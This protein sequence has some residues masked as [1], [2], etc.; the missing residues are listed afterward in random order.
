MYSQREI[1]V[2]RYIQPLANPTA[3]FPVHSPCG[4]NEKVRHNTMGIC[5]IYRRSPVPLLLNLHR[6]PG[7]N[8]HTTTFC[9]RL[10]MAVREAKVIVVGQTNVGKTCLAGRM[11][12]PN[13][14]CD[15]EPTA[16]ANYF[17]CPMTV[18]GT[19]VN[20]VIWDTAGQERYRQML[21]MYFR[22]VAAAVFVYSIVDAPTLDEVDGWKE[23]VREMVTDGAVPL[24]LVGTKED[25]S[26]Q[27]EVPREVGEEKA[28]AIGATFFETSAVTGKNLH[29]LFNEVARQILRRAAE[30]EPEPVS[31]VTIPTGA[32]QATGSRC[33]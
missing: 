24:F 27:R 14:N 7:T 13:F 18:D 2:V 22:D 12:D 1:L 29:D 23:F 19:A 20:L 11:H 28:R 10:L 16:G 33:C 31:C 17:R 30:P 4:Y 5:D 6:Q 21:S 8:C 15:T 26:A 25:L 32:Q 3:L 9:G